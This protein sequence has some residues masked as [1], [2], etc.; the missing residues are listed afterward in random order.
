[1]LET[2]DD[3]GLDCFT[4]EQVRRFSEALRVDR[5]LVDSELLSFA[6]F[7]KTKSHSDFRID[8]ETLLE[9]WNAIPN[10]FKSCPR[11]LTPTSDTEPRVVLSG[12]SPRS[13]TCLLHGTSTHPHLTRLVTTFIRQ[14]RPCFKF[15]TFAVREDLSRPPHRDVRKGPCGTFFQVLSSGSGGGLWISGKGGPDVK[16]HNGN[17]IQGFN[18]AAQDEPVI[19]DARRLL[20]A[21]QDWPE[22]TNRVVLIAWTVI[23]ARSLPLSV[24]QQLYEAGFQVPTPTDLSTE[25]PNDWMPTPIPPVAKRL[26]QTSLSFRH[27]E[28]QSS[29]LVLE[30]GTITQYID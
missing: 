25:V 14:Q 30:N 22:G 11:G 28:E 6:S 16:E 24:A 3:E 17:R 20:H 15:T 19:F 2:D 7:K 13:S 27:P 8:R 21:S 29:G 26:K 23:H 18:L 1:M 5:R 10:A 12:A 9:A 4:H